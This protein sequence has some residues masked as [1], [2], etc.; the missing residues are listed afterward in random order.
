MD[1][2]YF[3]WY[4]NENPRMKEQK[5]RIIHGEG[6]V[7]VLSIQEIRQMEVEIPDLVTQMAIGNLYSLQQKKSRTWKKILRM[8]MQDLTAR[9]ELLGKKENSQ[10]RDTKWSHPLKDLYSEVG[11]IEEKIRIYEKELE[12]FG[13][14]G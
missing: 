3:A 4:F 9:M 13:L 5:S 12:L 11:I 14:Q 7:K 8:E 1:A 2:H 10:N 6:K